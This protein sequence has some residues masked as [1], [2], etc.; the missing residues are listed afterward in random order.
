MFMT[1]MEDE[2]EFDEYIKQFELPS[3][4]DKIKCPYLCLAGEDDQLSPL[5]FTYDLY[6]RLSVPK[7]LVV[8]EGAVHGIF[9]SPSS[10]LGENPNNLILDWIADRFAGKPMKNEKVFIDVMGR[11]TATPA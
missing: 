9:G 2:G 5:E 10:A 11:A 4:A 1:G 6:D 3:I 8:Y 7:K